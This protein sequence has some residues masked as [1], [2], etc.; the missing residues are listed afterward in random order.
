MLRVFVKSFKV[1]K[2]SVL[3]VVKSFMVGKVKQ[4]FVAGEESELH[5]FIQDA[6]EV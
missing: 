6:P 4:H 5:F 2:T 3:G 1:P